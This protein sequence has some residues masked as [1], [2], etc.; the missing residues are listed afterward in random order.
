MGK[1]MITEKIRI[2]PYLHREITDLVEDGDFASFS[3]FVNIA[4]SSFLSR[5]FGLI[6]EEE[7]DN[8]SSLEMPVTLLYL[9]L[10]NK[11]IIT[12]EDMGDLLEKLKN[13]E[14]DNSIIENF[15]SDFM[16]NMVEY[17]MFDMLDMGKQFE[18]EKSYEAAEQVYKDI[19]DKFPED[20]E[21]NFDLGRL[22]LK[23]G[24]K[25]DSQTQLKIALKKAKEME[26]DEE[27]IEMISSEIKKTK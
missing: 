5:N 2:S 11:G 16:D 19:I 26:E 20:F 6:E 25:K 8:I 7:E 23:L 21:P 15:F 3:D 14:L 22:Y 27:I 24:K 1:S 13:N 12:Q 17:D 4:V 9:A 10:I 18:M